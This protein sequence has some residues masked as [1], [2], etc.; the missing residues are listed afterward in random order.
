VS[1]RLA[2]AGT[3]AALALV[4]PAPRPAT[5]AP[6]WPAPPNPLQ[7]ARLAGL[8][9]ERHEFLAY[10]VHA[11]LD[12]LVNGTKV[13]VP[14]G[15]G[16]DIHDPAV[17]GGRISPGPHGTAYGGIDN[18]ATPCISPL[19]THDWSGVLHTESKRAT[20]NRLGQFFTEWKV[21]LDRR[22]VGGYCKPRAAISVY[23]NGRVTTGNPR[24]ITLTNLKEIAIVIG[25]PPAHV[26]SRFP[27]G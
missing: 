6:P 17:Q 26:P 24:D 19:H 11:H 23:V 20:P 16:I 1:V 25:T 13:W 2:A 12:V 21:R 15:I 9:P 27:S 14:A 22:C 8:T 3:L 5:G 4:P 7:R 18:C 10:H